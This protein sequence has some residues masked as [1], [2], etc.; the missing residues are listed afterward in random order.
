MSEYF[1]LGHAEEVP[2]DE[3]DS[4]ATQ[5]YYLPMH[6]VHKEDSTTSKLQIVFNASASTA[7]G[8]SLNNHRLVGPSVHPRLIDVLLRFRR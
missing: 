2:L 5:V 8:T 7:S 1:H 6:A 4:P 3:V